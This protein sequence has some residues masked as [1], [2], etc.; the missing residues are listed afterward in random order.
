MSIS[1]E[2]HE[3]IQGKLKPGKGEQGLMPLLR[4][5]AS[6]NVQ[7]PQSLVSPAS[8]EQEKTPVVPRIPDTAKLESN[9]GRANLMARFPGLGA[10]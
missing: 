8:S 7:V 10:R 4:I 3:L 5:L 6:R 9:M 2:V 1:K